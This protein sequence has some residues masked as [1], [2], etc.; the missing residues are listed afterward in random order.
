MLGMKWVVKVPNDQVL[1]RKEKLLDSY[2]EK[3]QWLG[4]ALVEAPWNAGLGN[5]RGYD[6]G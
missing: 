3:T 1:E 4:G 5:N 6:E 2:N